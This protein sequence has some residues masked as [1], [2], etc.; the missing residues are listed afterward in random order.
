MLCTIAFNT[1]VW[2]VEYCDERVCLC[3]SVCLPESISPE[4]TPDFH[5]FCAR[6]PRPWIGPLAALRYVMYFWFLWMML[7][8]ALHIPVI[9]HT[10][11]C[12]YH[13]NE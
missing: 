6:Y 9:D 2:V 11:A 5:N 8:L 7:Y 12:L 3:V 10:E 13:C 4:N 1:P